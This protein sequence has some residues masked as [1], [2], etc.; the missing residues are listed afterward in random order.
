MAVAF[1]TLKFVRNL[2]Q[3]GLPEAQAE[4]FAN[5]HRDAFKDALDSNLATKG[6]IAKL[7]ESTTA[8]ITDFK[9]STTAQI[10]EFKESTNAQIAEFKEST[11]A[12]IAEFKES[13]NA[14]IA[15]LRSEMAEFRES[16]NSQ[17]A[18]LRSEMVEFK[19]SMRREFAEFKEF[20][21]AEITQLKRRDDHLQAQI[22]HL[23]WIMI[24]NLGFTVTIMWK[25]FS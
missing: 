22:S 11:N 15:E 21:M 19:A 8:Q 13:T 3:A 2:T 24:F 10:T 5:A 6:D 20:I 25:V 1:D 23:K 17:I 14:Q 4:I 16:T 9:E 7:K 18:E 12:Q